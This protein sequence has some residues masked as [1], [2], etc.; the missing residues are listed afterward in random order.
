[1]WLAWATPAAESKDAAGRQSPSAPWFFMK[2]IKISYLLPPAAAIT[3]MMA[4]S[5]S[6]AVPVIPVMPVMTGAD[7]DGQGVGGR[8]RST[9]QSE[10]ENRCN[11]CFHGSL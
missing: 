6:P 2:P 9:E 5:P 3:G 1:M 8:D 4:P 11:D 7:V 10:C